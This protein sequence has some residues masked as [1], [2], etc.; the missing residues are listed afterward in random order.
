MLE[1]GAGGGFDCFL[2]ARQVRPRGQ[3]TGVEVADF[4]RRRRNSFLR[5]AAAR[6]LCRY[7]GLTQR[8]AADRLG[9]GTGAAIS[10]R[11]KRLAE[12][13]PKDNTLQRRIGKVE[14][15]LNETRSAQNHHFAK[16]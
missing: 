1:L 15:I 4:E 13:L 2:A 16:Y 9:V 11:V 12:E 6:F 7:T 10:R 8:E 14:R 3:V 5:A